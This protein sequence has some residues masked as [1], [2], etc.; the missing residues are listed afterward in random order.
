MHQKNIEKK[1]DSLQKDIS[2]TLHSKLFFSDLLKRIQTNAYSVLMSAYL[3]TDV[4]L[5][6]LCS[7]ET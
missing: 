1:Y 7:L 4:F 5:K 2:N 6:V 3:I